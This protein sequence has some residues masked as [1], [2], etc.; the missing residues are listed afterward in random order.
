MKF[1]KLTRNPVPFPLRIDDFAGNWF[2]YRF[3]CLADLQAN[4]PASAGAIDLAI[5]ARGA[6]RPPVEK[7]GNPPGHSLF[8]ILVEST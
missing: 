1:Q 7:P 2:H 8:P 4:S 6:A 5:Q 3:L